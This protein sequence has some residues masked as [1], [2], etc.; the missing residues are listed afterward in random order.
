[1]SRMRFRTAFHPSE[2]VSMASMA[3]AAVTMSVV[4]PHLHQP[5]LCPHACASSSP[6]RWML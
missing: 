4:V 2:L 5:G 1:M 3:V 6:M